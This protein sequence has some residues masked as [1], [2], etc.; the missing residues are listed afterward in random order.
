MKTHILLCGFKQYCHLLLCKPHSIAVGANLQFYLLVGLVQYYFVLAAHNL[1]LCVN[2]QY[3]IVFYVCKDTIPPI[4][5]FYGTA[6][7]YPYYIP[8]AILRLMFSARKAAMASVLKRL[9]LRVMS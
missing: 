7:N 5:Q 3:F 9:T 1:V 2:T 8:A 6:T 4:L